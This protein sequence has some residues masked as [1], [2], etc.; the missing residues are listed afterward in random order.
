MSRYAFAPACPE[1]G[2][3]YGACRPCYNGG[4]VDD[5]LA[6]VRGQGVERVCC[7][8]DDSHLGL[9]DG[10]LET[11]EAA[12]GPDDVL[13]APIPDYDTVDSDT[14]HDRLL[15]FLRAGAEADRPT[16]VHCSAGSGRTGH[17]LVGWLVC[18]K[19][20]DLD[21]AIDTVRESG[22]RPLE[23]ADRE[24]LGTLLADCLD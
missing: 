21:S 22:R 14:F 6:F 8:L 12:F 15:P 9:Y 19:G 23:G 1:D 17:V 5:W 20:Y 10:L 7:L 4:T 24:G 11:Y 2:V 13:H 3:V 18:E 16:L